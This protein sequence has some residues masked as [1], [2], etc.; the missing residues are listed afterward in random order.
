[1]ATA[2]FTQV[3]WFNVHNCSECGVLYALEGQYDTRKSSESGRWCCPNGHWQ[4]YSESALQR[5]EKAAKRAQ[6]LLEMERERNRNLHD[7]KDRIDRQ[8]AAAWGQV[9]KLKRR[10]AHGVCPCCNRTFKQ[11][12]AHMKDK[13]PEFIE[14]AG[15][16]A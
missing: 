11:L 3:G 15:T 7:Q 1:M 10:A 8:R 5:S 9:T 6:E 13:H 16:P 12:A 14:K 4:M 2:T